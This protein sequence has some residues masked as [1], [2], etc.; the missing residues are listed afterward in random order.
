MSDATIGMKLTFG[1]R[2]QYTCLRRAYTAS[3]SAFAVWRPYYLF[4]HLHF[5]SELLHR[6]EEVGRVVY[7]S[8]RVGKVC[9]TGVLRN[10]D[11][12]SWSA[13]LQF[14]FILLNDGSRGII[15]LCCLSQPKRKRQRERETQRVYIT[16]ISFMKYLVRVTHQ[17]RLYIC[18]KPFYLRAR[19][20]LDY[21]YLVGILRQHELSV[22]REASY[23][24]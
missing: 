21:D 1:I 17:S 18:V 3:T 13:F 6:E 19:I 22:K 12:E 14:F 24:R 11:S 20:L 5:K 4:C 15:V 9:N 2:L 10:E 8:N 7:G 23:K 16:N